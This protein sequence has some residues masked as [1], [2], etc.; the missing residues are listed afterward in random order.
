MSGQHEPTRCGCPGPSNTISRQGMC[1]TCGIEGPDHKAA[2][3]DALASGRIRVAY[4][5]GKSDGH[6][7]AYG[8]ALRAARLELI[9]A[10]LAAEL[11]RRPKAPDY[12]MELEAS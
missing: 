6:G 7:H 5:A 1:Q 4:E 3:R 9:E 2:V 12:D 8:E 10:R 11:E